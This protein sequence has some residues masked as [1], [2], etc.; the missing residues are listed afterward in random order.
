MKKLIILLFIFLLLTGCTG[1]DASGVASGGTYTEQ[2]I[3]VN[4]GDWQLPGTLTLPDGDGPFPVVVF[5]HGS[6]P[7]DRDET[8]G[9]QKLF[10]DLASDLAEKGIASIRYDKRTYV[11]STKIV[12]D[13]AFTV[14]EETIDDALYAVQACKSVDKIDPARIY[15]AGHSLGGYLVP[16]IDAQDTEN[17]VAG[18][19]MLAGNVRSLPEVIPEQIDYILSVDTASSDAD[20]ETVRQQYADIVSTIN[21][22]TEADRGSEKLVFG[23]FPTY[24]L[25]LADYKPD[26]E[27][28]NIA[29]PILVLQGGHDYQ[30]TEKDFNLWKD[31]LKD[32]PNAV[33]KLFPELSHSFVKTENMSTPADY[34]TYNEVDNEVSDAIYSFING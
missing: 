24:W 34:N 1:K 10:K 14:K 16:R 20:K 12:T 27:V 5:V 30:V 33:F 8:L 13:V 19:I 17:S 26:V 4:P 15:V 21:S 32:N 9:K 3:T 18:Y 31:A 29:E 11:Y 22:L 23:A 28:K 2:E 25:D 7:A 6:G